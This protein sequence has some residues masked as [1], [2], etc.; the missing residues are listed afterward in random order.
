MVHGEVC[1]FG[2]IEETGDDEHVGSYIPHRWNEQNCFL[3]ITQGD[4][5]SDESL[6]VPLLLK[7]LQSVLSKSKLI[8][9]PGQ[10]LFPMTDA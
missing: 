3:P 1:G 2:E 6:G 8:T 4:C 9:F 10:L 7:G 5:S